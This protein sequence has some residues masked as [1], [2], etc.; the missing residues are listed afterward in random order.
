MTQQDAIIDV[1][2]RIPYGKFVLSQF[3]EK[4][5]NLL[6]INKSNI[7]GSGLTAAMRKLRGVPDKQFNYTVI[8]GKK[9]LYKKI[10]NKYNGIIN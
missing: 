2:Q 4:V 1:W 3:E 9:S 7:S 5:S 8:N 6:K 10:P